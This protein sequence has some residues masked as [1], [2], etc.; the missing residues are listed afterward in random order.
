[1]LKEAGHLHTRITAKNGNAVLISEDDYLSLLETAELL[2]IPGLK[3][4][5]A[6]A[7]KDISKGKLYSFEE[8]FD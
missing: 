7:D 5:I 8:I 4:S 1:V 6:K 3:K 2:S